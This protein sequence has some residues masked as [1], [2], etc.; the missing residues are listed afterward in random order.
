MK[1]SK[2]TDEAGH[3]AGAAGFGP[4]LKQISPCRTEAQSSRS[5]R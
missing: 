3:R 4:G 5:T 1:R 2:T